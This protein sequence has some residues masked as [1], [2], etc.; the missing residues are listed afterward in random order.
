[1]CAP[2]G[3]GFVPGGLTGG[4]RTVLETKLCSETGKIQPPKLGHFANIYFSIVHKRASLRFPVQDQSFVIM[5]L[6]PETN[7]ARRERVFIEACNVKFDQLSWSILP[8]LLGLL[9]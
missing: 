4:K 2:R 5:A 9:G 1:M 7:R 6:G 8:I 3:C